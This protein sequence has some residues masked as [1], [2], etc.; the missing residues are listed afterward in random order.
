VRTSGTVAVLAFVVLPVLLA[1]DSGRRRPRPAVLEESATRRVRQT[2]PAIVA[3]ARARIAAEERAKNRAKMP[4]AV[5]RSARLASE[6]WVNLGP[7][8]AFL[9]WNGSAIPNVDSGRPSGVAVDPRDPNVVYLATSG[10]GVW[11]TYDFLTREP[12][13][14]WH[15]ISDDLENLAIG[16][17]AL[18]ASSPDTIL[19]G[20]GDPFDVPGRSIY[21]SGD[22][23]STWSSPIDLE[24][25]YPIAAGGLTVRPNSIRDLEIDPN[26]ATLVLAATDVGLF[27]SRDGGASFELVDLHDGG[28]VEV[29][30]ALWSIAYV[31]RRSDGRSEWLATGVSACDPASL[32]PWASYGVTAGG[33]SYMTSDDGVACAAGNLGD[34]WR[35]ADAGSSWTSI[36]ESGAFPSIPP[37]EV[38][39]IELAA[40][41]AADP[42]RTVVYALLASA[43]EANSRTQAIW[44]SLDGGTTWVDATGTLSNPTTADGSGNRACGD[45]NLGH[46]QAWYNAAIAVDPTDPN[47]VVAGGNLCGVRTVIGTSAA[48]VWDNIAHWLPIDEG[49]ASSG[50]AL[51]YVH[52]DWHAALVFASSGGVRAF[53]L[54]DGG[55]FS[56]TNLFAAGTPPNR[57]VW[58]FHNRTLVTHLVW[59]MG[60]GDPA[61]GNPFTIVVGLQDNGVRLRDATNHPTTF[62]EILGGDGFDAAVSRGTAGEVMIASDQFSRAY[63]IQEMTNCDVGG[64]WAGF[65]PTLESGDDFPFRTR[66]VPIPTDDRG[67]AFLTASNKQVFRSSFEDPHRPAWTAIGAFEYLRNVS[68]SE[69]IAGLYGAALSGGRFAVTSDAGATWTTSAARIGVAG[70][71]TISEASSIDF[72]PA[73]PRGHTPGDVYL[74]ASEAWTLRDKSKVVPEAIGHLFVTEDR[75]QTFRPLHGAGIGH[76]LPNVPIAVV[77]YDPGDPQ[78]L[79]IYVGTDIG[80]YRTIDGGSTWARFG[81]G[82]PMVRIESLFVSRTSS[83][84]RVGTYGRG[85]WE[86]YPASSAAKGVNGDGDFDRNGQID[87]ADLAALASRLGTDPAT[88]AWPTYS[89]IDDLTGGAGA[90]PIDAIDEDDLV[91]LLGAFG[92]HP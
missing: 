78:S 60:S 53:A 63:C 29:P 76:D 43:D 23:G 54:S 30:E 50:G 84:I 35:S 46:G 19:I 62:D 91:L 7:T 47:H 44:R 39:R 49:G 12:D 88:T 86:I 56:S 81:G 41:V 16:A 27:R 51:P 11:K 17:I 69:T 65:D 45:L 10:G 79:T 82:L 4:G 37:G 87:W 9:E 2:L 71:G 28:G 66:V 21:R 89:A 73:T 24:G 52:A 74:A 70:T 32:P 75:G 80:L 64:N 25:T 85:I 34:I 3:T 68:A 40:S 5:R 77:R 18:A 14:I 1:L 8:D 22:G 55:I 58:S 20:T 67:G 90:A 92:G 15:P 42:T 26:D 6:T 61:T 38:G 36:R 48:P 57:V 33:L 72:P 59:G 31:G 13:P 83:L